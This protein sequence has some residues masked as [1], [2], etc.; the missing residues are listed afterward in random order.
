MLKEGEGEG[1]GKKE[2]EKEEEEDQEEKAKQT[3]ERTV[4]SILGDRA[5]IRCFAL[6]NESCIYDPLTSCFLLFFVLNFHL[7]FS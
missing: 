6:I 7:H 4:S 2:E 1:E 5:I 3:V